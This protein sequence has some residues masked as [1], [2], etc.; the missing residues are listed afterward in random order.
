[1]PNVLFIG[2]GLFAV[3]YRYRHAEFEQKQAMRWY[4]SGISLLIVVYFINLLLTDIYYWIAGQALFQSN[5]SGL[6]YVLINE[7]IWFACEVFFAV[8]LAFSV[9]RDDLMEKAAQPILT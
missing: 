3:I 4:F 8:G 5:S 9:F 2:G 6:T 1:L 7:P